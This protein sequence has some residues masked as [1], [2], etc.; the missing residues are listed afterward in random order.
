MFFK[1]IPSLCS[2]KSDLGYILIN[3]EKLKVFLKKII[4]KNNLLKES[5]K[6]A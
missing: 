4:F 6:I 5:L 3:F 2:I 1:I